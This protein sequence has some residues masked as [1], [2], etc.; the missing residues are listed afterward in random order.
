MSYKELCNMK[1][2]CETLLSA[3]KCFDYKSDEWILL[4]KTYKEENENYRNA[5][6]NYYE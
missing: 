5:L 6:I 2:Y 1:S 3:M 4:W